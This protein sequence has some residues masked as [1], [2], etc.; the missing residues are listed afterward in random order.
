MLA[1]PNYLKPFILETDTS[2]KGLGDVLTQE[3]DEGNFHIISYASHMLKPYEVLDEK[4]QL[5]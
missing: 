4:L 5:S 1:Y 2:L 3:D